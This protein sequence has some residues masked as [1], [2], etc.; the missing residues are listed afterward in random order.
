MKEPFR[1]GFGQ[2][3]EL[4]FPANGAQLEIEKF[5]RG[6]RLPSIWFSFENL[7]KFDSSAGERER[8]ST[9]SQYGE[10]GENWSDYVEG[11]V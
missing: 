8:E 1:Q 11:N 7:R 3:D 9:H 10:K 5:A 6:A 4:L 2:F